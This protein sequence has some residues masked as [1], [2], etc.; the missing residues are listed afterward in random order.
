VLLE[1]LNELD[2]AHWSGWNHGAGMKARNLAD[3]LR[4]YGIHSRTVRDGADRAK[5]YLRDDFADTWMRYLDPAVDDAHT[6]APP[7]P[8]CHGSD[9][10]TTTGAVPEKGPL[11]CGDTVDTHVTDGGNG[12]GD[13]T[14]DMR[15]VTVERHFPAQPEP[16]L[17]V[18]PAGTNGVCRVCD[19]Q[20]IHTDELGP[21]HPRC[22]TA[23]NGRGQP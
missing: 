13:V 14:R 16:V 9:A 22:L 3:V 12:K 10:V 17:A 2:E 11:T 15:D 5:G 1:R 21:V 8:P 6:P 4:P 20:C 18:L 23:P 7:S 19:R